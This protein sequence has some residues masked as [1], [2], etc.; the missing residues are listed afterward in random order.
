MRKRKEKSE[1]LWGRG[2][3]RVRDDRDR[4]NFWKVWEMREHR[5]SEKRVINL[6]ILPQ[7]Y[8]YFGSAL[9]MVLFRGVLFFICCLANIWMF[10]QFL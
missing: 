5:E 6:C 2:T 10:L 1:E 7:S 9:L 3:E 8:L 4:E